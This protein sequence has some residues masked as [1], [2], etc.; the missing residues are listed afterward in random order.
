MTKYIFVT[1][2][3]CSSLGKGVAASSLGALLEARGLKISL[4]KIDP[5]INVDPGT[6]SPYQHGEV[7]VTDDGAETD[8]DLGHYERFTHTRLTRLNSISTGQIYQAVIQ[9]ERQGGYL[10]QTVQMIPHITDEIKSR[11][12]QAA[13]Q[14]P[15]DIH[16]VE[17]GGTVGDI[18]G[19]PFLE[20]IRQFGLDVGKQNAL[21]LHLT[22]VPVVGS[23]QEPKTKPTQHS[24]KELREIGISPDILLCR[25]SQTL[26]QGMREKIALFCNVTAQAVITAHDIKDSIYEIPLRLRQQGL[27]DLVLERFGIEAPQGDLSDWKRI[28]EIHRAP[29]HE[30]TIGIIGKYTKLQDAYKSIDKA[31]DAG[32][33]SHHARVNLLMV[34]ADSLETGNA[35]R[36]LA[37]CDGIL[38]PGGFGSRGLEGKIRAVRYARDNGVPFL[39][40]CLGMQC[41]VI[42][43]A[44][45]VLSLDDASSTELDETTPHPVIHL[46]D[47]QVDIQDKGGTMRLGAYPCTLKP[48]SRAR[49]AYG[50]DLVWE[51]HR[52]RYEFNNAYRDRF[53]AQGLLVSGLYQEKDLVEIVELARHPWF[54]AVQFHP[55]FKSRPR[56]PHPLFS[57]LVGAAIQ[58]RRSRQDSA[59]KRPAESGKND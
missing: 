39:G 59:E 54:V 41:A 51:R 1:G 30:V 37:P 23:G 33:F 46:M 25:A 56:E 9:R 4:Q 7:Y 22:L 45:H 6:M 10:G 48:G 43:I 36:L 42:E 19:I 8:L 53:E 24:V 14:D 31:L 11:I 29:E 26:S 35:D 34:E 18:E 52:H 5:Y 38:I 15:V 3:V 27:D 28:V 57:G 49:A 40:I 55:E 12:L 58:Y 17:I 32:G 44:R 50:E 13:E 21:F 47:E 2:G 20:A 16:I